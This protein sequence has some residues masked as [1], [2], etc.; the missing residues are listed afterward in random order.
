MLSPLWFV[1]YCC[2]TPHPCISKT[3]RGIN[4]T[5]LFGG[6]VPYSC[7][8][9]ERGSSAVLLLQRSGAWCTQ[10]GAIQPCLLFG[11]DHTAVPLSDC[12]VAHNRGLYSRA[13]FVVARY[14]WTTDPCFG[15]IV[16]YV[17]HKRGL[18]SRAF[19]LGGTIQLCSY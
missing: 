1:P 16:P 19:C 17:V 10:K 14:A 13:C 15:Y 5:N 8:N 7:A 9:G 11:R 18:Y 6:E 2:H 4:V 12:S 3:K